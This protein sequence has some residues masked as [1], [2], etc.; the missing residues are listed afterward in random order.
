[1]PAAPRLPL[2]LATLLLSGA[3]HAGLPADVITVGPEGL[4]NDCSAATIQEAIAIA[5]ADPG[6]RRIWVRG[7][8]AEDEV[9]YPGSAIVIDTNL[10]LEITGGFPRVEGGLACSAPSPTG[11]TDYSGEGGPQ[12]PV[13]KIRGSGTVTLKNL[14]ISRGDADSDE[15][16]GIDYRGSG[17]LVVV[18]SVI[19]L[20]EARGTGGGGGI[21][22]RSNGG[23]ADLVLIQ[24]QV[25]QNQAHFGGG[26]LVLGTGRLTVNGSTINE[27]VARTS[28]GGVWVN[29]TGGSVNVYLEQGVALS[30]NAALDVVA[31]QN[32]GDGG[33]MFLANAALEWSGADGEMWL[34]TAA[35]MGGGLYLTDGASADIFTRGRLFP[36]SGQYHA[37]IS[38]NSARHGGGIAVNGVGLPTVIRLR[39]H[40]GRNP[41]V[42]A[43]N[44]ATE[45]GGAFFLRASRVFGALLCL[46]DSEVSYNTAAHGAAIYSES[47]ATGHGPSVRV[48]GLRSTYR[49]CLFDAEWAQP[50]VCRGGEGCSAFIGN[51]S[52]IGSTVDAE[53]ASNTPPDVFL[54]T[55]FVSNVGARLFN[56][57]R[58]INGSRELDVS[59]SLI[60]INNLSG[61]VL[62]ARGDFR[63]TFENN[64]VVNNTH[65]AP[66]LELGS[67]NRSTS[68]ARNILLAQPG[69]KVLDFVGAQPEPDVVED[70]LSND[71]E[72]AQY[73]STNFVADP[74]F[75]P[76]FRL[77]A[78]S[79]AVDR[80]EL[81]N[82]PGIDLEGNSRPIDLPQVV[83]LRGPTDLGAYELQAAPPTEDLIWS[84]GFE[85]N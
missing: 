12:D 47:G 24:T 69:R 77:Q 48:N 27:N 58:P 53:A 6:R 33:G 76:N 60:A 75:A 22:F 63:V 30:A 29:G 81:G 16:G 9:I 80:A 82:S 1:M 36:P 41:Q 68:V 46:Y 59:N 45:R 85:S 65:G 15:G 39:S 25:L 42:I 43:N 71:P 32:H 72:L 70:N 7:S 3:A 61:S 55:K 5:N 35:D 20:N 73:S 31:G 10:D 64:T 17:A 66:M 19:A 4:A 8:F 54:T 28:G 40:D 78:S 67:A 18:N 34:N 56:Y 38:A 44:D 57:D 62:N 26:V 52:T 21:S 79:P 14:D 49:E 11:R 84:D 13:F 51:Q 50:S 83:N 2:A 74:R 37:A 23:E